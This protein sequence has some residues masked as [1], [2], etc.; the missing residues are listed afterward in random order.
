MQGVMV[1]E[2][3]LAGRVEHIASRYDPQTNRADVTFHVT[4]GPRITVQLQGAHVWKRTQKKLIPI[5]QENAVDADLV[6]EGAQDLQSYF[7]SKGYFDVKVT[8]RMESQAAGTL[9]IYQ[10]EKGKRGR[11]T[12][13]DIKGNKNIGEDRLASHVQVAKGRF[14]LRGK[15]SQELLRKSVKNLEDVYGSAGYSQVKVTPNVV[16][17]NDRLHITFQVEARPP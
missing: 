8:S 3:Y 11:V 2:N 4:T 9:I 6:H 13:V 10:I 16:N 15:F 14:F 12:A 5:F 7:Q 1:K 17:Q